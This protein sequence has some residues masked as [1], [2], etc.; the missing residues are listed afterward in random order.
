MSVQYLLSKFYVIVL[1]CAYRKPR[2]FL[3]QFVFSGQIVVTHDL[4]IKLITGNT[5]S[6]IS[7]VKPKWITYLFYERLMG[8]FYRRRLN[9]CLVT[10]YRHLSGVNVDAN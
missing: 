6:N 1:V 9:W 4:I 5:L 10:L 2:F 8:D 3:N 7:N